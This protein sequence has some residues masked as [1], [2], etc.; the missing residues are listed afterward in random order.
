M[1]RCIL[2]PT[3]VVQGQRSEL[4]DIVDRLG[5]MDPEPDREVIASLIANLM[6]ALDQIDKLQRRVDEIEQAEG[7]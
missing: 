2:N 7:R 6:I 1:S 5:W 4:N 3:G